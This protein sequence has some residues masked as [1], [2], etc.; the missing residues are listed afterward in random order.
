MDKTYKYTPIVNEV[1]IFREIA[2]N[3]VN[4]LEV[5]REAISNS[6][7]ADS[8]E[9]QIDI[10]RNCNNDLVLKISDDGN[11]MDLEGIHRF[12]NLG[13]SAKIET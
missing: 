8:K 3:L 12:F 5:I 2:N 4:P 7:D 9:I 6:H 10:Y 11:G 1:S 13:D